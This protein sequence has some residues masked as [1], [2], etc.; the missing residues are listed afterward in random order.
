MSFVNYFRDWCSIC[1]KECCRNILS[2]GIIEV[3]CLLFSLCVFLFHWVGSSVS[4]IHYLGLSLK[5][6][7]LRFQT[8]TW[9]L[10]MWCYFKYIIFLY[11]V[12]IKILWKILW[13]YLDL[14]FSS[15]TCEIVATFYYLKEVDGFPCL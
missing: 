8:W 5:F 11:S 15:T 13:T 14:D 3:K 9:E 12:V 2:R 7:R 4:F 6:I 10:M 1:S